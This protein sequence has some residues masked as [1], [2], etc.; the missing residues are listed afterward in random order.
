MRGLFVNR[1]FYTHRD[2]QRLTDRPMDTDGHTQ[3]LKRLA[4][5]KFKM[6][7]RQLPA[8]DS[9]ACSSVALSNQ[10]AYEELDQPRHQ[11]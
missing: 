8:L 5:F 6:A 1:G 7:K 4:A 9:N 2:K 11:R 10:V 3:K